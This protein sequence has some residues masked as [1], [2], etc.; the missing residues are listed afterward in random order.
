MRSAAQIKGH[1]IHPI[2]IAFPVA[3][4]VGALVLDAVGKFAGWPTVWAAGAYLSV[5]AVAT[6]LLAGVPG[7]IDYLYAVPPNSSGK[8][9]ATKH[10]LVNVSSLVAFAVGWTFRDWNTFEPGAGALLL[11]L[12]GVGLITY[13][14]WLGGIL[15][16]RNQ[17]GVDH[18]YAE[19][20]K[21]KE[22]E[23]QGRPGE[24]VRVAAADELQVNQMKLVRYGE[25][26]IVLARTADGYVAFDDHCTHRGGSLAGGVMACGIV[27]CPWH[28][29]QF[30]V[31]NGQVKAGPADRPIG[32]YRVEMSGGEVRLILPG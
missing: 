12:L 30:D 14:G 8:R 10:M 13:G 18:R 2:L 24:A 26:R 28:G 16:Y 7:F 5:G 3:F 11:E 19:A 17:I 25:R 23:V 1:P 4:T 22:V 31:H 32:T 20:G 9:R 21:W 6:G 29:S 27:T 15:V